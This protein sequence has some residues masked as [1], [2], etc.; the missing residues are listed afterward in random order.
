M[1]IVLAPYGELGIYGNYKNV[2]CYQSFVSHWAGWSEVITVID[3]HYLMEINLS[4]AISLMMLIFIE[5]L[6]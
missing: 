6:P 3:L 4:E 1:K 2:K 5:R